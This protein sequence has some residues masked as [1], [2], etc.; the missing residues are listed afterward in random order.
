MFAGPQGEA[1]EVSELSLV[2]SRPLRKL[3]LA[4]A[5]PPTL[6][7][8]PNLPGHWLWVGT[9]ALHFVP[10]TP[11]LPGATEFTVTVPAELRAL[12]GATLGTPYQFKFQ[13]PLPKLVQSEPEAGARGLEPSTI[14]T[15]RFNQAIDPL[16]FQ[17]LTKLSATTAGKEQTLAFNVVRPDPTEPKRLE[18]HPSR[19][20]PVDSQIKLSTS[21]ELQSLEGPLPMGA[22]LDLAVETYGPLVVSSVNCDRDTPHEKC[23]PGAS[24]SIELSNPVPIKDLKR[25]LAITP[26]LPLGFENWSD[27]STPISYL[28]VSAPFQAGRTYL[29]RIS[30]DM[31]DVHGQKLA[32]TLAQDMAI[33]DYFPEV[34]IGVNGALLDPRVATSVPIG[35]VN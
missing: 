33:D 2:F 30:G 13:T 28:S 15:L 10:E 27:E 20:L 7:V 35:S 9:H 1:S 8:A 14:F 18:V 29:L 3:E 11:H 19:P 22:P 32:K 17:R 23:A 24:W 6:S 16:K 12:D 31:R 21:A 4:G 5:P 34:E 25:A 26:A